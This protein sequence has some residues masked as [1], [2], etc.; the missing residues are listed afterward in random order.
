MRSVTVLATVTAF[1]L[2]CI[3]LEL[4]SCCDCSSEYFSKNFVFPM[5]HLKS[6][7]SILLKIDHLGGSSHIMV[8]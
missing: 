4:Y 1:E 6:D 5:E 7:L 3:S 8:R 2:T